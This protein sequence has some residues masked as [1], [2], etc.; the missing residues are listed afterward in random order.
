MQAITSN[1]LAGDS[2]MNLL[3]AVKSKASRLTYKRALRL[4]CE[5]T[6]MDTDKLIEIANK[7][8]P[9]ATEQVKTYMRHLKDRV[10][11]KKDLQPASVA[12]YFRTVKL[13]YSMNDIVMNWAKLSKMIPEQT[14]LEDRAYTKE[15]INK[16]LKLADIREKVIVLLLVTAGLRV[17]AL[18]DLQVKH[19]SP[20]YS[21][22]GN[23]IIAGILTVYA[24]TPDEYFTFI[25][26][27]C[28]GTIQQYL[29][30]RKRNHEKVQ[31][32]APLIRNKI[33]QGVP[34]NSS[35]QRN[36]NNLSVSAILMAMWRLLIK[37]GVRVLRDTKR[38][39]VK[40]DH[41][42]RKFFNTMCQKSKVDIMHK[43]M[44][45]GHSIGLDDSYYRPEPD[46]LLPDYV[47][48]I[49]S[50]TFDDAEV[51]KVQNIR[52]EKEIQSDREQAKEIEEMK[53]REVE[54]ESKYANQ[55]KEIE[56]LKED[57]KN[58][59]KAVEVFIKTRRRKEE[60]DL[61]HVLI[62][63]EGNRVVA[64][65]SGIVRRLPSV[66]EEEALNKKEK[67]D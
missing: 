17:G 52:L 49:P 38:Y 23:K 37:S 56:S 31:E 50:L 55:A 6:R 8:L 40:M 13:F 3:D 53:Q 60:R 25:T 1:V 62:D 61:A 29:E 42:F 12:L 22:K 27:E 45:M 57:M 14:T 63:E 7:N 32:D 34:T 15:E 5:F 16:M 35:S 36:P 18:P 11:V 4:Y 47:K 19:L 28:Y 46:D 2:F 10:E 39:D 43:E 67:K 51:L 66:E 21:K 48:V 24:N 30:Y 26:P 44:L 65:P 54:F 41:G 64:G 33:R 9:R 59:Q 20:I 58:T